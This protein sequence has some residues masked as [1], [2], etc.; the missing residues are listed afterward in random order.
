MSKNNDNGKEIT[1]ICC[2]WIWFDPLQTTA[3]TVNPFLLMRGKHL[4]PSTYHLARFKPPIQPKLM[5]KWF[6]KYLTRC[7][8]HTHQKHRQQQV[9][10]SWCCCCCGWCFFG[11]VVSKYFT[12]AFTSPRHDDDDDSIH[13]TFSLDQ[14]IFFA[15]CSVKVLHCLVFTAVALLL[16][17]HCFSIFP[18]DTAF[19]NDVWSAKHL[20]RV[21]WAP[22]IASLSHSLWQF[23]R[24]VAHLNYTTLS[25][26]EA[27]VVSV[28]RRR[29]TPFGL[30][31]CHQHHH[32]CN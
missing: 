32:N 12:R 25:M 3:T 23:L 24:L 6:D 4:T 10:I 16:L 17:S 27:G 20:L 26:G 22:L 21:L 8:T 2:I 30:V 5:L 19:Q 31:R 15:G 11:F 9:F 13:E 7:S 14:C 29:S 28:V 1:I 18:I